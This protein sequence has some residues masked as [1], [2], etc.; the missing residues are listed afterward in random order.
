[1][2]LLVAPLLFVGAV[3]A[4]F[5]RACISESNLKNKV[6]CPDYNG[7]P[8]GLSSGRGECRPNTQ[9]RAAGV[10]HLWYDDR[11]SWPDHHF[12]TTCL[13][14]ANYDGYNCGYCKSGYTGPTCST[15][16]VIVRREIREYSVPE[17]TTLFAK[18]HYCKT[19][20]SKEYVILTTGDRLHQDAFKFKDAS[21][22]DI[23]CFAHY[24]AIK[25]MVNNSQI[26]FTINFA[27]SSSAFLPWHRKFLLF[28]E[29]LM[30]ICLSDPTFAVPYYDWRFDSNCPICTDPFLGDSDKQGALSKYSVF[31][32]WRAI[33]AEYDFDDQYCVMSDCICERAKIT[34]K[35]GYHPFSRKPTGADVDRALTYSTYDTFPYDPS[36][37]R[38]FRNILEGFMSAVDGVTRTTGLHNLFHVYCGGTMTQV[39]ISAND[40]MFYLHHAFVD[41]IFEVWIRRYGVTPAEYPPNTI[42][43]HGP[44]ECM[45]PFFPCCVTRDYLTTSIALGYDYSFYNHF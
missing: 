15:R 8:C 28:F 22:Y 16:L 43:G 20:I 42:Y 12:N 1:M 19:V 9:R 29:H 41:K 25:P 24:Y 26:F 34:R 17:R 14:K 45:P 40:P 33:C 44:N 21:Y 37:T 38:S 6:C 18:L 11:Y 30:Q 35:P 3:N 5:P 31:S 10:I 7:S 4:I 2:M 23:A 32:T 27:H 39:P 36:S 13:C